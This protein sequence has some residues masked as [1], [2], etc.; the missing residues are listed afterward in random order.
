MVSVKKIYSDQD[1][2][3]EENVFTQLMKKLGIN[4]SRTSYNPKVNGLCEKSNG[5]VKG[6]LLKY[7]NI[8]GGVCDKWLSMEL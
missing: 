1:P 7:V 6:F 8:F 4:K 3:F 5:I 2:A